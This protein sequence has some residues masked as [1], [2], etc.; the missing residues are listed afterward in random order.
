MLCAMWME[1]HLS[2][3]IIERGAFKFRCVHNG[4]CYLV[5]VSI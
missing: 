3:P 4:I 5:E 2:V 1:V